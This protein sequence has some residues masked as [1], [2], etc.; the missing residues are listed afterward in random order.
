MLGVKG[1]ILRAIA[2]SSGSLWSKDEASI[3]EPIQDWKMEIVQGWLFPS[4]KTIGT[5]SGCLPWKQGIGVCFNVKENEDTWDPT[6]HYGKQ[7]HSKGS[8]L[9]RHGL[10]LRFHVI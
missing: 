8:T 10:T 9:S 4:S 5:A 2:Q 3:S 6:R 7:I 1:M